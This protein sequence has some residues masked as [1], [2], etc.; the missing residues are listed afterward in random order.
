MPVVHVGVE[1]GAKRGS[2]RLNTDHRQY[3]AGHV[4][5]RVNQI[6]L[7][8]IGIGIAILAINYLGLVTVEVA[9]LFSAAFWQR[10]VLLLLVIVFSSYT[11]LV[12]NAYPVQIHE[13]GAG[14]VKGSYPMRIFALFLLDIF[15]VTV[16]ACMFGVLFIPDAVQLLESPRCAGG[17][18]SQ[19]CLGL[20]R[21]AI[22]MIFA[23]GVL[24]HLAV[25]AWYAI[26]DGLGQRDFPVHVVFALVYVALGAL[27]FHFAW[28]D[29]WIAALAFAGVLATLFLVQGRRWLKA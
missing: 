2:A 24:W 15:Q 16:A 12:Y 1:F 5:D 25:A 18:A 3:Y 6:Q 21:F 22:E 19:A 13:P 4:M 11:A 8:V 20:P 23:L 29:A 17:V 7:A 27:G 9:V 28:F 10:V 26:A 14:H